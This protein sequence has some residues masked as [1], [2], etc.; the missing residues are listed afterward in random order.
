MQKF[1]PQRGPAKMFG[2]PRECFPGPYCGSRRACAAVQSPSVWGVD[3]ELGLC[4]S[5]DYS[6]Y[7]SL[8]SDFRRNLESRLRQNKKSQNLYSFYTV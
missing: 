3:S 7:A 1:S 5:S 4:A 8:V 6:K 2:A